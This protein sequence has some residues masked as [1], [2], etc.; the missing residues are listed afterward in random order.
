M[1]FIAFYINCAERAG[2]AEVLAGTAADAAVLVHSRHF[3]RAVWTF[4]VHHLDGSRRAVAFAVAA[5]DA[6]GQ[7]H[8]VFFHP[9]GV[10][11]MDAC[12]FF[13]CDGFDGSSRTHLAASRTFRTTIAAFK[14][15]DRLHEV[16]QVG[17]GTQNI[18]RA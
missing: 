3:H 8:A 4:V 7:H 6:I 12:L 18:V 5:A 9:D 15:H 10:A 1:C 11:D 14:R 16:H 17:G 2:R 13:S